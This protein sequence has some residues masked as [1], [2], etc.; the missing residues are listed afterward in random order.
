MVTAYAVPGE[1][2]SP[3]FAAA[4]A[5]GA[6]GTVEARG[7]LQA[8]PVALFGSPKRWALLQQAQAEGRD[9][10]Y[11]DHAYFGRNHFYRVTRNA[12]Q[13]T[14]RAI[15]NEDRFR[16]LGVTIQPWR[17]GGG[18]VL[19]CPPADDIAQLFN[20]DAAAWRINITAQLQAHTDRP[21]RVRERRAT[22]P[23]GAD[24]HDCWALVTWT[25]N[26]AV[27]AL[28]AGVPVFVTAACA[29]AAMASWD[30]AQIEAPA[31]P[32]SRDR[33]ARVLAAN[34][35]T[36]DEIRAGDCWRAIGKRVGA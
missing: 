10:Y 27:E 2:T 31:R 7:I 20:F 18:H 33:W 32:E 30:L 29:A 14:G 6:G 24:L 34:Q 9:W 25:S 21:I 28:C 19:L 17:A 35:W 13:H 3:K 36:L 15:I 8:G 26:A 1:L 5:A 23:L 4:F 22:V 11:G 12:W 16:A